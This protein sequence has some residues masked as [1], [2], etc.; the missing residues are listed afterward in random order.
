MEVIG[1]WN[2]AENLS[3]G[4]EFMSTMDKVS[5]IIAVMYGQVDDYKFLKP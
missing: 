3:I 5:K 4:K 1:N 2:R